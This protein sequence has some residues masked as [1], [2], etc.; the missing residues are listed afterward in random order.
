MTPQREVQVDPTGGK[1]PR[2]V[3]RLADW[4]YLERSVHR[5][6][7]GWG[8][9]LA[10]WDEKVAV[11]RHIWEQAECV[12]RIRDRLAEFP[13]T[14]G[15]QN[16]PV[17]VRLERLVNA[18]LLAPSVED[19][20]DGIH[21]ILNAAIVKS[22]IGY[23]EA[24][25]PVHDAPTLAA[26][27]ENVRAKE[28][29]RLWLRERRRR[30]PHTADEAYVHRLQ[31]ALEACN[32]LS[33]P[34][35]VEGESAEPLGVRTD[36]RPAAR[37]P[38][39]AGTLDRPDMM[40]FLEAD[41]AY[42]LEARRL[43]WCYAYMREMNLAEDQLKWIYDAHWMPWEFLQDVTRHMWDESRHGQSGRSRLMD[44][45]IDITETG[46]PYYD[47]DETQ[48]VSDEE[49][50]TAK[51]ARMTPKDL[52]ENVFF[53][54]MVAETGHFAVKH[55]AYADFKEGGDTESAEMMIFDII[56]ETTHV[57]YAHKWLPI[58]AERAG[59]SSDDFKRRGAEIR[60]HQQAEADAR[61]ERERS[62][63]REGPAYRLYA[64]L[65]ERMRSRLPLTNAETCPR[66]SGKPM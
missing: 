38:H 44:F 62:L 13:G 33:A 1:K 35:P 17:S 65:I 42:D 3:S 20:L 36:F 11:C 55:E 9:H 43:F 7:A 49:T 63:P 66:R 32:H 46:F 14:R 28:G 57:Q 15:N 4:E 50:Q 47:K 37:S 61:A 16:R 45:G 52:Y 10:E 48:R 56:D 31:E 60:R 64:D 22:Y 25:H 12:R 6:L 29:F 21:G 23:A 53:I 2:V 5:A 40:P 8:R 18:A 30:I 24:A 27:A 19:A 26:V 51:A 54:G 41:F 58:L 34:I 39:P 59:I